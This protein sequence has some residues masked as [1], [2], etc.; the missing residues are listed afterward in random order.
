MIVQILL[1]RRY[2]CQSQYIAFKMFQI[3]MYTKW[4]TCN[5]NN[6]TADFMCFCM[7]LLSLLCACMPIHSA[8]K[9]HHIK[10]QKLILLY[11]FIFNL[12]IFFIKYT[13]K[14]Q[15][16]Q[17]IYIKIQNSVGSKAKPMSYTSLW[18]T[19]RSNSNYRST[20]YLFDISIHNGHKDFGFDHTLDQSNRIIL[21]KLVAFQDS[22]KWFYMVYK[23]TCKQ[24]TR[25][26]VFQLVL[27]RCRS[28]GICSNDV[29]CVVV[30]VFISEN[31]LEVCG[32]GASPSIYQH[33]VSVLSM[34]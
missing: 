9:P 20:M 15:I 11:L 22:V 16:Q 30:L 28:L 3:W 12:L 7:M 8:R 19:T 34:S 14:I 29:I 24:L 32:F 18:E 13:N 10:Y 26:E 4:Q 17:I 6:S 21:L 1:T 33:L 31:G 23:P 2:C 27:W 25:F 5:I